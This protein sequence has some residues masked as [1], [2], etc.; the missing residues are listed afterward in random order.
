MKHATLALMTLTIAVPVGCRKPLTPAPT[1]L[2]STIVLKVFVVRDIDDDSQSSLNKIG[3]IYSDNHIRSLVT[4]LIDRS[5]ILAGVQVNFSWPG[6][7][8]NEILV[9][10][11]D[12]GITSHAWLSYPNWVSFL[13]SHPGYQSNA[14]NIFF[15]PGIIDASNPATYMDSFALDPNG[16]NEAWWLNQNVSG[17]RPMILASDC[18]VWGGV[19][20]HVQHAAA[21]PDGSVPTTHHFNHLLYASCFGTIS[22]QT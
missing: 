7:V 13:S 18:R 20:E 17:W 8:V 3:Y 2:G 1:P 21:Q 4:D 9:T 22:V 10:F 5:D 15:V 6:Q 16:N 11:E 19:T 14:I 12:S